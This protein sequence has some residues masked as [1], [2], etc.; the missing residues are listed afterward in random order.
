MI[1]YSVIH[2]ESFDKVTKL[3][4]NT[5]FPI[6]GQCSYHMVYIIVSF[7]FCLL[8]LKCVFTNINMNYIISVQIN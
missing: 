7:Y 1:R 4:E 8:I 5:F 2:L 6:S 3:K